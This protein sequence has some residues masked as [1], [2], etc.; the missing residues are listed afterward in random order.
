M[1]LLHLQT[2]KESVKPLRRP[3]T[4]SHPTDIQ[5][6]GGLGRVPPASSCTERELYKEREGLFIIS[7]RNPSSLTDLSAP[8]QFSFIFTSYFLLHIFIVIY[9]FKSYHCC[10]L[11]FKYSDDPI[12]SCMSSSKCCFNFSKF[13]S[14][15]CRDLPDVLIQAVRREGNHVDWQNFTQQR[16]CRS[17]GGANLTSFLCLEHLQNE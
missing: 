11:I 7:I 17:G 10:I 5:R 14:S 4:S 1:V 16:C 2:Y 12:V 6:E 15:R 3:T 13:L 8:V 9:S